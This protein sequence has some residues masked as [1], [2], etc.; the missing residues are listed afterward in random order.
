[1]ISAITRLILLPLFASTVILRAFLT[2]M[3][4]QT[5]GYGKLFGDMQAT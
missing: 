1:M 5:V 2:L 3:P 4:H